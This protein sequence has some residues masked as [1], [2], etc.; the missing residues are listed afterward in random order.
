MSNMKE[1]FFETLAQLFAET[2]SDAL[3]RLRKTPY[4]SSIFLATKYSAELSDI[5][6]LI[7]N[8]CSRMTVANKTVLQSE[9]VKLKA[10]VQ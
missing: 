1:L 2:D 4:E 8:Y 6:C 7:K 10:L 5:V 9:I 3:D